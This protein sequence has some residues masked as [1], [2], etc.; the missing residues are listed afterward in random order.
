MKECS[1]DGVEVWFHR[2]IRTP[3][4]PHLHDTTAASGATLEHPRYQRLDAS[5]CV[6]VDTLRMTHCM[7]SVEGTIGLYH[8]LCCLTISA[9]LSTALRTKKKGEKKHRP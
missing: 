2:D 8:F 5:D 1:G 7:L 4:M 3:N 9:A 6:A